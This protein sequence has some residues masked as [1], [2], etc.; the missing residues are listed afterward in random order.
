MLTLPYLKQSIAGKRPLRAMALLL[1]IIS[2]QH[3]FS[4]AQNCTVNAGINLTTCLSTATLTGNNNGNTNGNPTWTFL[5][6]PGA[7]PV[8]AAPNSLVTAVSGMTIPGNYVFQLSQPCQSGGTASQTVTITSYTQPVFSISTPDINICSNYAAISTLDADLPVGWTGRWTARDPVFNNDVTNQLVF[9]NSTGGHT[10]VQLIPAQQ[11]C[12]NRRYRLIWTITS[13]NGLCEYS[14]SILLTYYPDLTQVN[15]T[16]GPIAFCGPP[17]ASFPATSCGFWSAYIPTNVTVSLLSAP[18]GFAGTLTGSVGNGTLLVSGLTMQGTYTFTATLSFAA[19]P[20]ASR[21]YGP[22]TAT[23]NP[24]AP[25]AGVPTSVPANFC[26]AAAPPSVTFNYTVADPTVVAAFE[27]LPD[28]PSNLVITTTGGGTTNRTVTF[29]PVTS[30]KA[31]DF[32]FALRFR[33]AADPTGQCT[34]RTLFRIFI[35]DNVPPVTTAIPNTTACI[36]QGLTTAT[37]NIQLPNLNTNYLGAAFAFLSGWSI[38]KI[39]G[40]AT[41][42]T[43]SVPINNTSFSLTGLVAGVYTLQAT[44]VGLATEELTCTGGFTPP[45]FTITVY[46]QQGANAGTNQAISCIQQFPLAANTIAA[47]SVGTWSQVSGPSPVNFMPNAN[48]PNALA[49]VAGLAAAGVYSFRWTISDPNGNCPVQTSD[50]TITTSGSCWPLPVTLLH[51]TAQKQNEQV[52]LQWAT[53]T[54]SN[55]RAFLVEW[56]RDGINWQQVG[57]VAAAGTSSERR[58][59]EFMH[60]SP[61]K[62]TNYYRLQQTDLDNTSKYTN[63]LLV[64]F[65]NKTSITVLPNPVKDQL[66]ISGARTGSLLQLAGVDGRIIRKEKTGSENHSLSMATC[67]AGIYLLTLTDSETGTR[68]VF[69]VVKN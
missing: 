50:V 57:S 27:F 48:D 3:T 42:G 54:E 46:N 23:I 35:Y 39:S 25:A 19:C 1:A 4:N 29:A 58:D 64:R 47:P 69:K 14:K 33:N 6:G 10:T 13:P 52:R 32:A 30:W 17:S 41:G 31:G 26:L 8:I 9:S 60:T 20:G 36:P 44:P 18:A 55:S 62:G 22:F 16:T 49:S 45:V 34:S 67:P 53:A 68:E 7:V 24:P 37:A 51:F 21:T 63:I 11:T 12:G 65:D 66:F 15:F 2:L 40:P 59:Y 5:S 43:A 61:V 38:T 56:S 28:D